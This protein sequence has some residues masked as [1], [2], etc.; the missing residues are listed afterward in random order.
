MGQS[1]QISPVNL[2]PHGNVSIFNNSQLRLCLYSANQQKGIE[3]STCDLLVGIWK[4]HIRL[5]LV[6]VVAGEAQGC[7]IWPLHLPAKGHGHERKRTKM[8]D[9][10]VFQ[11]SQPS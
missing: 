1:G 9:K 8:S 5:D 3:Y 7:V 4:E 6:P 11:S 2:Q 10:N